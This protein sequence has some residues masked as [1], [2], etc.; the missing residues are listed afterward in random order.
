[1][2]CVEGVA[3]KEAK[4]KPAVY[5]AAE[6]EILNELMEHNIPRLP[7]GFVAGMPVQS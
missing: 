6:Q 1:M 2:I 4:G 3:K 5:G 7:V